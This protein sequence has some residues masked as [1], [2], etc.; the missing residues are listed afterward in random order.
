MIKKILCTGNPT[1]PGI[2][3]AVLSVFPEAEFVSRSYGYDLSTQLG[4]TKF[5]D[6]VQNF[7]VFINNAQ[8]VP[9][10]QETLLRI[11]NDVWTTGHV[12]NIG[13]IAEYKKWE[14]FDPPYTEE[15]RRLKE[16]SLDMCTA[17]F[18]TT[19]M[20]VGGFQDQTPGHEHKLDPINIVNI[21]KWILE[22]EFNVPVIGVERIDEI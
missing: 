18:K 10:T 22:C 9:G 13:S 8:V 12:F 14:W 17:N 20:I 16:T 21:I 7:D 5:K 4:L 15:K 19:H 1:H 2:A 11:V 6:K 3:R